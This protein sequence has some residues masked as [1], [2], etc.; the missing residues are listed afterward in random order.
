[1]SDDTP[2]A[3]ASAFDPAT[4]IRLDL[5]TEPS[6]PRADNAIRW[7]FTLVNESRDSRRLAFT[8]SQLGEVVLEADGVER[9]RWSHGRMFAQVLNE[10]HVK[11]GEAWTFTLDDVLRVPAGRYVLSGT[12]ASEPVIPSVWAELDVAS[13]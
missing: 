3:I 6:T 5:A 1:M 11:P 8:S 2:A 9:Y 12:V 10:R 4:G 7:L 13:D